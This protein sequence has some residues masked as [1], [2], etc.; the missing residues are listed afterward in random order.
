MSEALWNLPAA[1]AAQQARL[2]VQQQP[3]SQV[4][5]LPGKL[6][7]AALLSVRVCKQ[8]PLA[9]QNELSHSSRVGKELP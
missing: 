7:S 9:W 4:Y 8:T 5:S 1:V 6:P 3:R 2:S